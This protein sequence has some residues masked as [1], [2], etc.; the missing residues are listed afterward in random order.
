MSAPS[1][2]VRPLMGI[3]AVHERA[4]WSFWDKPAH[5]VADCYVARRSGAPA[6]SPLILPVDARSP[7]AQLVDALDGFSSSAEPTSIPAAYGAE[8]E[9]AIG[10]DLP[11]A[12][13]LRDRARR[14]RDRAR[15]AG[16][17]HLPRHAAPQRGVRRHA[18]SRTSPGRTAA[19]IHRRRLGGFDGPENHIALEEGSLVARAAGEATPR[20]LLPS[21]PGD[22]PSRRGP[23]RQRPR[24]RGRARGSDREPPTAAGCSESSGT[25]RRRTGARSCARSSRRP[26]RGQRG[27]LSKA[28]GTPR[29]PSRSRGLRTAAARGGA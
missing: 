13:C 17:R 19:N 9:P 20:R 25:R 18:P 16:A 15:P 22:R 10:A 7:S 8:P 1:D 14:K 3:C 29:A 5:L 26:A 11:R 23:R 24:G 6:A 12:R 28:R 21:P 2:A 27:A 4:R